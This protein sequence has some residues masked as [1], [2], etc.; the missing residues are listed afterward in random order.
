MKQK[1]NASIGAATRN[2][3]AVSLWHKMIPI[4][5]LSFL[6]MLLYWPSLNYPF[7]FDDIA[8]ISKKFTIR[9]DNPLTRWWTHNR[10]FSD[11]LNAL[12]FQ[13]GRFEPF[14]YRA[15]NVAIHIIS[16]I[17]IF[18]LV[19][20]LCNF[21]RK[22]EFFF[23]NRLYLATAT[24]GL[25]LLH[26]V[27]TQTVSY[28]IQARQEGLATLFALATIHFFVQFFKSKSISLKIFSM[29]LCLLF[30]TI[31]CGIKEVVVVVPLLLLLIDWFF[32]AQEE[33]S[34]FKKHLLVFSL[35][36]A[37]FLGVFFHYNPGSLAKNVITLNV[38]PTVNNRGN[39]LTP[40]PFDHITSTHFFISEFKVIVHYITMF[41]WPF[42]ISVEYDWKI[43]QSF[44]SLN[45]I[46][47]LLLLVSLLITCLGLAIKKKHTFIPFGILWFLV[48]IAPRS[49]LI[50]SAEL[51]CDY[52]TYLASVGICFILGTLLVYAAHW[53]L[54]RLTSLNIKQL[55]RFSN[56]SINTNLILFLML[57]PIGISA[58][59]R[60]HV[61]SSCTVFWEDNARKAPG[62]ARV[63]NNYGVALSEEGKFDEAIVAYQ[64]AI[65][66]DKWYQDPLSNIAVAYSLTGKIDDA[67]DS[68]KSALN[69]CP[70]YPEAY[71]NIGSLFLQKK[72]YVNAERALERAVQLRPYYGKAFYNLARLHEEKNDS[73]KV[74]LYLKKAT[75]GDLDIPDVFFKYGQVC[76]R[77]NKYEEAEQ[78]FLTTI[79]RG[80]HN[81]QVAFNLANSYYML[82]KYSQAHVI[83][84]S[85]ACNNPQDMRYAFNL[86]ETFFALKSYDK[87]LALF[88]RTTTMP[89]PMAQSFIR[90]AACLE[91]MKKIGEAKEYL[92]ELLA[93]NAPDDFKNQVKTK[94]AEL[95]IQEKLNESG[96]SI[97]LSE[98]KKALA[99]KNTSTTTQ[100]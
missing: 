24:A 16:G 47:P 99:M 61:W 42:N 97:K 28:V 72:D 5:I 93:L 81:D 85:L 76:L 59:K 94:I 98:L 3:G 45:V 83:Y 92:S 79:Q 58:L 95:S 77:M 10:W 21:L 82:Q 75:E 22:K 86:A 15:T 53:L 88:K 89:N 27:Q 55:K 63:H 73:E 64:K 9:F 37:C 12:N 65:D 71:N 19:L 20:N 50:P 87:A 14:W 17:L 78:A 23:N 62:K 1:Y 31:S 41:I 96:G 46:A 11:W 36:S 52:K 90:V 60:N 33:W 6:T 43:T 40:N 80:G 44:F 39:I 25:F 38:P 70:N 67:I 69:L 32:I 13:I 30:G 84:E 57:T 68:L 4:S 100:A 74:L 7:Q 48:S 29:S 56:P 51:V 8:N 66:L 49:T 26:P 18:F 35:V 2:D 34:T 91:H 54:Q